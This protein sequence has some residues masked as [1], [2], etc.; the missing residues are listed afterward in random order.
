MDQTFLKGLIQ[1]EYVYVLELLN[2]KLFEN[3]FLNSQSKLIAV[4]SKSENKTIIVNKSFIFRNRV[5]DGEL[6][7]FPQIEE[8]NKFKIHFETSIIKGNRAINMGGLF[9]VNISILTP[10]LLGIILHQF[11]NSNFP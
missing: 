1:F 3:H 8:K 4:I 9:W 10:Q 5:V 7:F 11:L 6:F 2:C